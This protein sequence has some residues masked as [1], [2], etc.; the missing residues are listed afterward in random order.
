MIT[1]PVLGVALLPITLTGC[2]IA[3]TERAFPPL[4]ESP[5]KGTALAGSQ[6]KVLKELSDSKKSLHGTG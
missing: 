3:L 4:N 2:A 6:M 1:V 5:L